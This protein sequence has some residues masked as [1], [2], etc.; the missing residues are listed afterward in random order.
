MSK[1]RQYCLQEVLSNFRDA[2]EIVLGIW[3][4]TV[5]IASPQLGRLAQLRA[6]FLVNRNE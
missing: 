4:I 5:E 3:L 6:V 2:I 1:Y